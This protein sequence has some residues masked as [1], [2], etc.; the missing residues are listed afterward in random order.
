MNSERKSSTHNIGSIQHLDIKSLEQM[1]LTW[2]YGICFKCT[3]FVSFRK[4]WKY[5]KKIPNR[6]WEL[7]SKNKSIPK[8]IERGF[9]SHSPDGSIIIL[10]WFSVWL[11]MQT[12]HNTFEWRRG[13]SFIHSFLY[14]N[15][16]IIIISVCMWHL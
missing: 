15:T 7:N 9:A 2:I 4:L 1:K 3:V 5:L 10:K 14:L 12:K 11:F 16:R 6:I 8:H 13:N